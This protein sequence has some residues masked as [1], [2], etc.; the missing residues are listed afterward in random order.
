MVGSVL[1]VIHLIYCLLQKLLELVG[2]EVSDGSPEEL[3]DLA[4]DN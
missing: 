1:A 2:D 3:C 4:N